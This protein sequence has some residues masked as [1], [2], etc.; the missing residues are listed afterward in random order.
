MLCLV[1]LIAAGQLLWGMDTS[2]SRQIPVAPV[3]LPA[4]EIGPDGFRANWQSAAGAA[5]YRIDLYTRSGGGVA[6]DLFFSEYIE[7]SSYNKALEIYNGTG[8]TVNL[9]DYQLKLFSNGGTTASTLNLSG[10]LA[11]GGVYVLAH[12]SASASILS[13]ADITSSTV[14]NFNGDDAV[15]L[16]KVSTGSYV[17]IFGVIGSDPGDAWLSG[18][19][20]TKDRTLVRMPEV[21]G[22][23]TQNPPGGG[24]D[25]FITLGTEWLGY[26]IDTTAYLGTHEISRRSLSYVYQDLNVG[27]VQN[28][29]FS[30]LNPDTQ[31]YYVVR[32]ANAEGSSVSSNEIGAFTQS[33]SA[34]TVPASSIVAAVA[35]H[36]ISLEWTPGNGSRRIVVMNTTN[37]FNTPANGSDPVP[38]PLYSGSGQQVVYNGAT[39]IIEEISYNGVFVEGLNPSTTYHFRVFE[40]NGTGSQTMYL[41]STTT[42]NPAFFTTHA[43]QNTGYYEDISGYGNALK[44]DLHDLLRTTHSTQY[45]YDALWTQLQYTDEDPDNTNNIIEVYSGWS[46]PKSHYGGGV[47]EWNREHTWSK[48]HGDFG[49]TR[50]AGTDLHHLRPCDATVNSSKGNKDFDEGGSEYIDASPYPGYSSSTGNYTTSSTW[51]PR[52]EDKGDVARMIMYMAVRYE[53]TDTGYDLEV[54]DYT[55]TAPD[56]EP[57]YGKLSTLLQWH[58][59][60]PVDAWEIRRNDRIFERQ[61][62]RNPFIDHPEFAQ[63]LWTPVPQAATNVTMISFTANWSVPITGTGYYLQVSADSLFGSFITGYENYSA[64]TSISKSISGLS[65]GSTYYYRLRTFFT[66]GYSMFSP[67]GRVNLPSPEPVQTTLSIEIVGTSVRLSISPVSGAISYRIYASDTPDGDYADIS[68]SGSF[69]QP[70]LWVSPLGD[71][72]KRFYK[73]YAIR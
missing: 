54:V 4:T 10:T 71:I 46:I 36:D 73:A 11:S 51:E 23:V 38:N 47:T 65:A 45:S 57:F 31:Y 30:G 66:N 24:T 15:A 41:A 35:S 14:I 33:I 48:S 58:D 67:L 64:G 62:N 72:P 1:G 52:D 70:T 53:G 25:A 29:L 16:Y 6:Q 28:W 44:A 8:S 49:E 13:V 50:P 61:G 37:Y 17:D 22:G 19:L 26:A 20:S 55:N 40:Y 42:G 60:D 56:Y 32:A 43:D 68:S 39:E 5:S 3:A 18:P 2:R 59:Q 63:Y 21:T 69:T 34:P 27:N 7:G 9:A 12:G